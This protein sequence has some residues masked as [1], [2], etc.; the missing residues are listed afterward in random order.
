MHCSTPATLACIQHPVW[1]SAIM[2]YVAMLHDEGLAP[3][4]IA[5]HLSA[6]SLWHEIHNWNNPTKHVLI[7]K[8]LAGARH[9]HTDSVLRSSIT[10]P[11]MRRLIRKLRQHKWHT[12]I[13]KLYASM[14]T[15]AF[16]S[17]L[18]VGE[19]T[20]SVHTLLIMDCHV[21]NMAIHIYFRSFKFSKGACPCLTI[22]AASHDLCPH[23]YMTTH[24]Q[25]RPTCAK[26]LFVDQN[27]HPVSA[28]Q[29]TADLD[30]L[31]H[32][33]GWSQHY[34]K[35]HSF[36]I[37]AATTAVNMGIPTGTIHRMG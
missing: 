23:R 27:E 8:M 29:F 28:R 35:P 24:L 25:V 12:Y 14:Y 36:H 37:S 9:M 16:Y 22:P 6:V 20:D 2:Q 7:Q 30:K 18:R 13:Q 10:L 26:A 11:I 1:M 17:F 4:T 15:L 34:I 21:D 33:A 5:S 31:A 19:M 3:A 32:A